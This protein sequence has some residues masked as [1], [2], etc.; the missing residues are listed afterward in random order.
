MIF[1]GAAWPERTGAQRLAKCV[2][3]HFLLVALGTPCP[4]TARIGTP[5]GWPLLGSAALYLLECAF[6]GDKHGYMQA[7]LVKAQIAGRMPLP[8]EPLSREAHRCLADLRHS[9]LLLLDR[10]PLSRPSLTDV[11]RMWHSLLAATTTQVLGKP[12]PSS[13]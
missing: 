4:C 3:F 2:A 6:S 7:D 1:V 12:V 11:L 8:W 13:R 10:D 9:T 5:P